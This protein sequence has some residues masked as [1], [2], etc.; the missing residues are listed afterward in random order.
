MT[1]QKHIIV[2]CSGGVDSIVLAHLLYS[3]GFNISLAHCNF[4][5]RGEESNQD[6]QFVRDFAE[7]KCI[8]LQVASF[9]TKN[10]V[11]K[12]KSNTQIEARN[13]RYKWFKELALQNNA[14]IALGHHQDD[15]IETFL[16]QLK[17]GGGIRGLC[18]MQ[19]QNNIYIRPLLNKS[20]SWILKYAKNQNLTWREDSS[21]TSNKYQR[22]A[23]R[24]LI[25]TQSNLLEIQSLNLVNDF[26]NLQLYLQPLA[27]EIKTYWLSNFLLENWKQLPILI[28]KEI[29]YQLQI[30]RNQTEELDKLTQSNIGSFVELGKF[31]FFCERKGLS[32]INIEKIRKQLFIKKITRKD[33]DFASSNFYIDA[34][35]VVGELKIRPRKEVHL[36]S[37][38]GLKGKKTVSKYLT[39]IKLLA[40]KKKYAFVI[41]DE[42]GVIGVEYGTIDNRVRI[43]NNSKNILQLTI[44]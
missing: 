35:K 23:F 11:K 34:E 10:S 40:C 38:Y 28:K 39:D 30:A 17:R 37:P 8:P 43:S 20:R 41:E 9:D 4:N 12:N 16:I 1:N 26:K 18:A 33:I 19:E 3:N 14:V 31:Q 24:N 29:L 13:L 36:F 32:I 5:L 7:Q 21:N 25:L 22:N 44:K 42:Q 27:K 6:E 2:G 15:Q